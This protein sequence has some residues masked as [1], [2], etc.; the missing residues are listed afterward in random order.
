MP[1]RPPRRQN[2]YPWS[3]WADGQEHVIVWGMHFNVEPAIMVIQIHNYGQRHT[4][5]PVTR[6]EGANIRFA[7]FDD[8]DDAEAY[9]S[10]ALKPHVQRPTD[11]RAEKGYICN[12]CSEPLE[13]WECA[14]SYSDGTPINEHTGS[15]GALDLG[16]LY[17]EL[18]DYPRNCTR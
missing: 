16:R 18:G 6:R 11:S 15:T 12:K 3:E 5:Y 14:K 2:K 1:R 17:R 9:A 7:I 13:G 8:A 10:G 4:V